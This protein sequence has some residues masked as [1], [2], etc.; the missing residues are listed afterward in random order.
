VVRSLGLDESEVGSFETFLGTLDFRIDCAFFAQN[1]RRKSI[2]N[3]IYVYQGFPQN[4][5]GGE[6]AEYVP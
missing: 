4:N 1:A 5:I 3:F 6:P 2:S